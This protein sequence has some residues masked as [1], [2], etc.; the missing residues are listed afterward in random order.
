MGLRKPSSR[1]Q[2]P[3]A[4][5]PLSETAG[6]TKTTTKTTA[7]S[8]CSRNFEQNLI[9]YGVYPNG[10]EIK[11]KVFPEPNNMEEIREILARPR[12][13]PISESDFLKLKRA[14]VRAS[15]EKDVITSVIPIIDGEIHDDPKCIGGDW[16]FSNLA[17]LT[18]GSIPAAKPDHHFGARPE[19]VNI[20]IRNE[21]NQLIIPSTQT[22]LPICQNF[23]LE[24][25]GP[26]GTAAVVTR[27]ACYDGALAARAM[28]ALRCYRQEPSYDN[29]AYAFTSTYI[30]S[31]IDL[32]ATYVAESK[33]L[34]GR[35]EYIMTLI[36]SFSLK[37][38]VNAFRQGVT[39]Y[40]NA[41][42]WAKEK[43]DELIEAA[44][45]RLAKARSQN[46]STP[47]LVS[48]MGNSSTSIGSARPGSFTENPQ[49]MS[50]RVRIRVSESSDM[51][52][53]GVSY[54]PS[55]GAPKLDGDVSFE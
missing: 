47:D 45:E 52:G 5:P 33:R 40:R 25:K 37:G 39:A 41:R 24:V 2:K 9:E 20:E 7:T 38:N 3:Q 16:P 17:P 46:S 23:L 11:S 12:D 48:N 35:P 32:Y 54:P 8:A 50:T 44:N 4:D 28:Q 26:D 18:D 6:S 34:D 29:N 10:H 51:V 30:A 42:D 1:A 43:R 55:E 15:K 13:S 22:T 21:L 14:D 31:R 19:D 27:Q 53:E 36:D 49:R